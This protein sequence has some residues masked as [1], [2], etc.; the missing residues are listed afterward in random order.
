MSD[1]L[2]E[3][4]GSL[5]RLRLNRPEAINALTHG[6]VHELNAA[7]DQYQDDPQVAAF[8]LTGEGERGLCAGGDIRSLYEAPREDNGASMAFW[9]DE[10]RLDARIAR[11]AKPFVSLMDGLVMGGGIGISAHAAFRIVTERSKIA[12]PECG[13]GFVPD[14]GATWL[15]PRAPGELG[16][17]MGLTG[18]ILGAADAILVGFADCYM[19]AAKREELVAAL[20]AVPAAAGHDG[21]SAC[22]D[23]LCEG[24]GIASLTE[25]KGLIDRTFAG[26]R[27]EA[28][29][30]ALEEE[31]SDFAI[32][33]V[34]DIRAKSPTSLK[35]ALRLVRLGAKVATL[36]EA[37]DL[38]YAA[39]RTLV[40][41]PDFYEGIRAAIIDKDR[42]PKWNPPTLADVSEVWVENA[43]NVTSD[44]VFPATA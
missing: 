31:T 6:M 27:V 38:E 40:V 13:I 20:A 24:A 42:N 36:E 8:L 44:R 26:D 30:A 23:G 41:G 18:R 15:L 37:L 1:V 22:L 5:V 2:V 25:H 17:W 7:L 33:T 19:P 14:V 32:K 9:R 10:Y 35:L 11:L 12:M 3:R 4:I 34:A 21:V 16:T 29:M 43:L 39:C 28:I